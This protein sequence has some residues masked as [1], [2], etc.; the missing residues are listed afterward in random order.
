MFKS[1]FSVIIVAAGRGRRAGTGGVPKQFC[2][3][4]DDKNA[5]DYVC[6]CF[7][8]LLKKG[9]IH[10]I[11]LV[12]HRDDMVHIARLK[13]CYSDKIT[14]VEGGKTRCASVRAGLDHVH[15]DK[16]LIHDGARPCVTH[17]LIMRV[18]KAVDKNQGAAPGLPIT[19]ALWQ[20]RDGIVANILDRNQIFRAQ[21]PQ[22]FHTQAIKH[23][24][25]L[26]KEGV[27]D[28]EIAC[29]A[30][31]DVFILEGEKD[32]MKI[33]HKEDFEKVAKLCLKIEW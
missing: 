7:E 27:D 16:V 23:A 22:G 1:G 32:N 15:F 19:D 5:L 28:V 14:Y 12:H 24:Y 25:S 11:I 9:Y 17:D 20:A 2:F 3:L 18:M 8:S 30:G 6:I 31:I 29:A 26:K 13:S 21:T 10:Q 33:T 4:N